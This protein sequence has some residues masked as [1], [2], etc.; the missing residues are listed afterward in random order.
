MKKK[1]TARKQI[2][3][4]SVL[5]PGLDADMVQQLAADM[6]DLSFDEVTKCLLE[7]IPDIELDTMPDFVIEDMP[8]LE[9]EVLGLLEEN[10]PKN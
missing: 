1:T 7:N 5:Y 8:K 9:L 3:E 6:P 2:A 4:A 10:I